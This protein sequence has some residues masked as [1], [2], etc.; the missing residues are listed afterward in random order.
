[1]ARNCPYY[2]AGK[3]DNPSAPMVHD[4]S[5][6]SLEYKQCSVYTLMNDPAR[7]LRELKQAL[8]AAQALHDADPTYGGVLPAAAPAPAAAPTKMV[9]CTCC[10]RSKPEGGFCPECKFNPWSNVVGGLIGAILLSA[11]FACAATFWFRN[12]FWVVASWIVSGFF[13]LVLMAGV[14]DVVN[15]LRLL[16][17]KKQGQVTGAAPKVN[18]PAQPAPSPAAPTQPPASPAA[19]VVGAAVAG[20]NQAIL[21]ALKQ[22]KISGGDAEALLG[23]VTG[24]VT[25]G[26]LGGN[27]PATPATSSSAPAAPPAPLAA[28]PSPVVPP[29]GPA[30]EPAWSTCANSQF[31]FQ[32]QYPGGWID[33]PGIPSIVY[34]PRDAQTFLV[35]EGGKS[36]QVFSP[37]LT[38]MMLPRGNTAGQ[39]PAQVFAD[40]KRLLPTYFP[41]YEC[42]AEAPLPLPDGQVA[43][44]ITFDFLKNGRPF[45]SILAYLVRPNGI[46]IFDGSCLQADFA[47]YESLLRQSITSLRVQ[48]SSG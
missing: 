2:V 35:S 1:M 34:H 11:A 36:T 38:L 13:L 31:G 24:G 17:R 9:S 7:G 27:Q 22:G 21:D 48:G 47:R 40:F 39:T 32:F 44:G 20:A 26:V 12:T 28:P 18:P 4:C 3:C 23:A 29:A 14:V 5:W 45:R 46:F 42:R 37:A 43:A 19:L 8:L 6:V 15:N 25:R 33:V 30:Q 16:R 10:G 41:G